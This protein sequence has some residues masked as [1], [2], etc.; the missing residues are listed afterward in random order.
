[1]RA[2]RLVRLLTRLN[3]MNTLEYRGAF[4]VLMLN[5][6]LVPLISLLVWLAVSAQGVQL[7]Y[8]R[9]QFITYYLMLSFVNVVTGTWLGEFLAA[10]IR[11]GELSPWLLRPF[12]YVLF[13]IGN[14]LGEKVVK[15][16]MLVPLICLAVLLFREGLSLP[17]DPA[18]WGLFLLALPI[19]AFIAFM[20]DFAIGSLA[21]WIQD[22]SGIMRAQTLIGSFLAGELVPLA[23]FPDSVKGFLHFQ[24]FRYMLSFPIE[25]LTGNLSSAEIGAGFATGLGY[26]I[27][28]WAAYKF[29]WRYGLRAYSAVGA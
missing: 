12:P 25:I 22:V 26:C 18:R 15:L 28:L 13:D 5:A 21:F 11:L 2:L 29:L 16:P 27:L 1:M 4:L 24:P 20:S 8:D 19:A 9:S 23:L 10:N 14:N 3:I 6:V 7:P 17:L